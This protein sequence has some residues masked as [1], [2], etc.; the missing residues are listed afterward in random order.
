MAKAATA[1]GQMHALL[2]MAAT[3]RE[4]AAARGQQLERGNLQMDGAEL[5]AK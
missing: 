2:K 3:W 5:R 1:P 4:L